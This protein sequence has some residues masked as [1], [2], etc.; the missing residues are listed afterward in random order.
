MTEEQ[1]GLYG[2]YRILN[3]ATGEPV[4]G[5]CFVLKLTDVHARNALR[6]YADSVET[7]NPSLAS[8]LREWVL[9]FEEVAS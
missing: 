4:T 5:D 7:E 2:K 3:A 9:T 8:D 6:A 1:R